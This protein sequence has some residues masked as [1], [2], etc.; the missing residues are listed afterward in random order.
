M[1]DFIGMSLPITSIRGLEHEV[2]A[3]LEAAGILT[4]QQLLEQGRTEKQRRELATRL[5]TTLH[6]MKEAVNR[7]DLLRVRGI[8]SAFSNLLEEAG[9]NS[10]KELQHRTPEHLFHALKAHQSST[11]IAH[12]AP[13]LAE[14]TEWVAAAKPLAA[15]SPE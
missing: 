14:V 1:G 9:V 6:V 4:T 5:G 15:T 11:K 12:H 7:A 13:T 10:C 3:K 2:R 8:G